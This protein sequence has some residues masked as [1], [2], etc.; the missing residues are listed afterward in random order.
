MHTI[1]NLNTMLVCL[2]LTEIDRSLIRY[3][4]YLSQALELKKVIFFHAIQA[5]DLPDKSSKKFPDLESDLSTKIKSEINS[6]VSSHFKRNINTDVITRIENEDAANV[7]IDFTRKEE[8]DL[9]LIGQK[10]GEDRSGHYGHK[11]AAEALTDLM[12]IPEDPELSLNKILCAVDLSKVSEKAFS[13]CLDIS[14]AADA[15]IICHY[16]YDTHKSYFP[17][18]TIR[19]KGVMEKKVRKRFRKFLK[20][21]DLTPDDVELQLRVNEEF[22]SQAEK[23]YDE[24]E[25]QKVDLLVVGAKG[26]TSVVTSLLGNVTER[27][28]RMEKQMPVMIMKNVKTRE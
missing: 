16:L 17:A 22:K 2:D 13:R 1:K 14:R 6:V 25:D 26:K 20:K 15:P 18:T 28:R 21:F 5:Y 24:A 11:I 19:T 7:I 4:S 27:L 3:A 9:A 23:L 12:F 8:V 10:Y